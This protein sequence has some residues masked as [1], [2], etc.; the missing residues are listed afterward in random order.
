MLVKENEQKVVIGGVLCNWEEKFRCI[1]FIFVGDCDINEVEV[2]VIC[3]V[4]EI[5]F[6]KKWMWYIRVIIEYDFCNVINWCNDGLGVLLRVVYVLRLY[7]I[8][9]KLVFEYQYYL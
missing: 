4:I 9:E 2:L 3:K 5:L 8:N 7:Q 1:F 6:L